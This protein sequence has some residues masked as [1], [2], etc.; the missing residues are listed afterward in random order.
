MRHYAEMDGDLVVNVVVADDNWQAPAVVIEYGA[1]NPAHI[2]GD[3][4]DGYFYAPQPF[5]SWTRHLGKWVAPTPRPTTPGLWAWDE[6]TLS[7]YDATVT[8]SRA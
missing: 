6:N 2:G 7:W 1:D 5:A 4:V 3:Y 8:S